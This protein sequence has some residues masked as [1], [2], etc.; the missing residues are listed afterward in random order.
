M[1]R[2]FKSQ[3]NKIFKVVIWYE[4]IKLYDVVLQLQGVDICF[5]HKNV[6]FSLFAFHEYTMTKVLHSKGASSKGCLLMILDSF[7][8]NV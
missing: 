2:Y 6:H 3:H 5:I 8:K 7:V 4:Q 1:R